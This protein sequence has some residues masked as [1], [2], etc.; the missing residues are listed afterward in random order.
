MEYS[1]DVQEREVPRKLK[2]LL[3]WIVQESVTNAVSHGKSSRIRI[4][5]AKVNHWLQLRIED[6]GRGFNSAGKG[7]ALFH[8]IGLDYMQE[9]VESSGGI[10]SLRSISGGGTTIKAEW[11]LEGI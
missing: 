4:A 7:E 9:Q 11:K 5:L 8:G 1:T 6:N 2:F 10:F 3:F